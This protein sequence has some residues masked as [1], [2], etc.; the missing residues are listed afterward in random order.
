MMRWL[1]FKKI[2]HHK[3][4]LLPQQ[5][6]VVDGHIGD[7]GLLD[8]TLVKK[9]LSYTLWASMSFDAQRYRLH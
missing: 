3:K 9:A 6:I 1:C 2:Y 4:D 5:Y 8:G 7:Q